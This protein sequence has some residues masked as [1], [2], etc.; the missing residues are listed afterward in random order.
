MSPEEH[1]P[2]WLLLMEREW[3]DVLSLMVEALSFQDGNCYITYTGDN[4][5]KVKVAAVEAARRWSLS[6][7]IAFVTDDLYNREIEMGKG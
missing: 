7:E 4:E 2:E 1:E 5:Y 6:Q 3:R